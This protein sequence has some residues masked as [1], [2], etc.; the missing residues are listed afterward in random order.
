MEP[1]EQIIEEMNDDSDDEYDIRE[2]NERFEL[3][4]I[5]LIYCGSVIIISLVIGGVFWVK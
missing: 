2:Y 4:V 3:I 1:I 5:S